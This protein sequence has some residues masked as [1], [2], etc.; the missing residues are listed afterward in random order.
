MANKQYGFYVEL[1]RCIKCWAC[2]VACKQWHGIKAGAVSRRRVVEIDNGEYPDV[3]RTF[4]SFA[5]MHCAEP[6]CMKVCPAGAISKR[7][8][9]GI[10]VVDKDKCI[11]CHYCF[12]ACPFG[13]PQYD[14]DGMDKCD[15]CLDQNLEEGEKPRC[16]ATCPTQALHSGTM[17]ELSE[18]IAE[19]TA[20][21][22]VS[23]T[24]PSV[25]ISQ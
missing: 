20:E 1:D 22:L 24:N 18:M 19:K 2:V 6:A 3:T 7:S 12:F 11:G 4:L 13:V 10:V 8:E 21:K 17:E 9:D 23:S 5:C 25:F 15:F 16:V 14:D